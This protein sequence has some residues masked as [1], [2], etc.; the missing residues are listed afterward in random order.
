[1]IERVCTRNP[2]CPESPWCRIPTRIQCISGIQ[3]SGDSGHRGTEYPRPLNLLAELCVRTSV[4]YL[5]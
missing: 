5:A 3:D 1:M 2:H 4:V